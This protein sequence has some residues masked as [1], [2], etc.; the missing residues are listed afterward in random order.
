MYLSV[1]PAPRVV[2]GQDTITVTA[3]VP[4]ETADLRLPGYPVNVSRF[5]PSAMQIGIT[6]SLSSWSTY[7]DYRGTPIIPFSS[8]LLELKMMK[9]KE[10]T[11]NLVFDFEATDTAWIISFQVIPLKAFPGLFMLNPSRTQYKDRCMQIDPSIVYLNTPKS[12]HLVQERL[13]IPLSPWHDNMLF[14]VE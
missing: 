9:G 12:H 5:K 10:V 13:N 14:Y 1:T 8:G 11:K 3:Y 4:Y 2:Y 6:G 7:D